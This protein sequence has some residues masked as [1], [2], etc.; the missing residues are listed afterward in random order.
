M[1]LRKADAESKESRT[2]SIFGAALQVEPLTDVV[3]G[4][5]VSR[6]KSRGVVGS[7]LGTAKPCLSKCASEPHVSRA[8]ICMGDH[9]NYKM[10]IMT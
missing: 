4:A 3:V 7:K 5:V 6:Q 9:S 1:E 10:K 8:E 2:K